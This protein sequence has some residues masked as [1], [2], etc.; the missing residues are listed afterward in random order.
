[1]PVRHKPAIHKGSD[2]IYTAS[3]VMPAAPIVRP[4][5]QSI[6]LRRPMMSKTAPV[7]ILPMPLKTERTPTSVTARASDAST[8]IARSLAKEKVANN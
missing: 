6:V 3:N 5:A 2:P 1:M 4:L 8:E 7:I